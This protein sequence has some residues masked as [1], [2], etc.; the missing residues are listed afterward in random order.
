MDQ[1][2]IARAA[3]YLAEAFETG[4]P[5]APLPPGLSP[6]DIDAG[7]EVAGAVLE[8]L[9]ITPCGL[10]LA[11]GPDGALIPGPM[12]DARLAPNGT[13]VA[14]GALRHARVSAAAI[15]VLAE[16]LEADGAGAPV[17]A[18]VH[19]A[20]D[21]ASSRY[22]DGAATPAEAVADLAGIGL[23]V[24][25]RRSAWSG[26]MP[27]IA[28]GRS[29]GTG[30]GKPVDLTA[31]FRAAADEARRWG[32]LPAGALLVVAG[33]TPPMAPVAGEE[34]VARFGRL[35]GVRAPFAPGV[36]AA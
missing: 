32:G 10:R 36:V 4:N 33:L 12:L 30:T 28:F 26:G 5:L 8:R 6:E 11:P 18:G 14:L 22:R 31:A 29:A 34:W 15:G 2:T 24:A 7:A 16:A 27:R 19:P 1:D 25:G 13:P 21:V 9:G 3:T 17:L 20:I 35:G 23:V